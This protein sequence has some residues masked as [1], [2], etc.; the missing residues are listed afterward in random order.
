MK[1]R[2][3]GE[4]L[5]AL[6]EDYGIDTVF[7][8]PGVHTIE[9]YRGLGDRSL[10]HV[11]SRHEQG[12]GFMA[13]GYARATG[14]PAA[15]FLISGPGLTNA[16]TPIAQAYSDSQPMV[17]V[18]STNMRSEIGKGWGPFHELR[19]QRLIAEQFCAYAGQAWGP[20]DIP[21]IVAQAYAAMSTGRPRPVYIEIPRDILALPATGDWSVRRP[22]ARP[23]PVLT[24]I[25]AAAG[26]LAAA[27]RP[28]LLVG[29]GASDAAQPVRSLA[30][31]IGMPVI[32]SFCGKGVVSETGS[33]V[34]GAALSMPSA[35]ALVEDAD[36]VLAIGTELSTVDASNQ[37][38]AF[39][40]RLIRLDVDP[41]KMSD[42]YPAAVAIVS[43]AALGAE[44]LLA[45]L[46]SRMVKG[47]AADWIARF[48]TVKTA[49]AAFGSAKA[50]EHRTILRVLQQ[51]VPK[52]AIF[53]GDMTQLAY[54]GNHAF[55]AEH[56]RTWLHPASFATL[57]Y[58]LPTAIGA[59]IGCPDRTIVSIAGD[60]GFLFTCQELATAAD[61]E[62]PIIQ[63]LWN[64]DALGEIRDAM[65]GSQIAPVEVHGRNPDFLSLARS[66][67]WRAE[68]ATSLDA[69][70]EMV[71][72]A[73]TSQTPTLIE[74][75][76]G[77]AGW[78]G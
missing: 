7:G 13:D 31:R 57:G 46:E 51:A 65:V 66:F 55:I 78:A 6:L 43:D 30:E 33:R 56:P 23:G 12:A 18:T 2:T 41:R 27:E 39:N 68:R 9:L 73:A 45:A 63:I 50:P 37:P 34:L 16:A 29:A 4:A 28:L 20:E 67:H 69:L 74:V 53:V 49:F 75:N 26:M 8:I 48:E 10:R 25:E 21:D 47:P 3:C 64:N 11:L 61:R 15:C 76:E 70:G 22:G 19:N 72:D 1:G 44:A 71:A 60:C 54:T 5:V 58:A 62:I 42:R 59:K 77:G 36:V 14:R 17:V 52:D 32:S 35:R 40:G 24:E 38:L